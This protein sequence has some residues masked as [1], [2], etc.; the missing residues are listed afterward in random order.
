MS[1]AYPKK[2]RGI[3]KVYVPVID[4]NTP[5]AWNLDEINSIL[6]TDK[7]KNEISEMANSIFKIS[8]NFIVRLLAKN[9]VDD[10]MD[11]DDPYVLEF[12]LVYDEEDR[13]EDAMSTQVFNG[14]WI[15]AF[16]AQLKE[17]MKEK[18]IADMNLADTYYFFHKGFL[19][20]SF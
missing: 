4:W 20:N 14:P 11:P 7:V 15:Y 2:F 13:Y 6:K 18:E 3:I 16:V 17:Y 12:G 19:R 1:K 9:E 10:W 5:N 8:E